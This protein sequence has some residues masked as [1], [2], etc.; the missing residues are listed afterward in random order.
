VD[1]TIKCNSVFLIFL[2]ILHELH[3]EFWPA[4]PG[5]WCPGSWLV[6]LLK[7]VYTLRKRNL[8]QMIYLSSSYQEQKQFQFGSLISLMFMECFN[9][10]P[11]LHFCLKF[12][13]LWIEGIWRCGILIVSVDALKYKQKSGSIPHPS[14]ILH[15]YFEGLNSTD[16]VLN[17]FFKS[18]QFEFHKL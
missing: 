5:I 17:L 15:F 13:Y 3:V 14:F 9:V 1:K 8:G 10:N 6:K 4:R 12:S 16:W 18:Y 2:W 7:E 11:K